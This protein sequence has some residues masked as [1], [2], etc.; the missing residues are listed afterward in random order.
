MKKTVLHAAGGFHSVE[1]DKASRKLT[2]FITEWGRYRSCRLV[3]GPTAASDAY[4]RR[5]DEIIKDVKDKVNCVDDTTL[6][7]EDIETNFWQTWDYLTI[8]VNSG[9]TFNKDKFQFCQDRVEFAGLTITSS[10]IVPSEH[11]LSAIK[12]FPTPTDTTGARSWSGL[13]NQ[14]AWAYA[15]SPVIQPFRDLV[16]TNSRFYWDQNL[17]NIFKS[18][19]V[20]LTNQVRGDKNV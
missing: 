6:F 8:C 4:T 1:L 18:S 16:K 10:G 20:M 5:Y 7:V 19:K 3:Q 15:I 12:D 14:V 13:V 17:D 9:I 2:T 11:I